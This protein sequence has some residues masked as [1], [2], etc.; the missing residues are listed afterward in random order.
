MRLPLISTCSGL[1]TK[2][3]SIKLAEFLWTS[4]GLSV[5]GRRLQ[6]W[7]ASKKS[8]LLLQVSIFCR[9]R[10]KSPKRHTFFPVEVNL[11]I[12]SS[13]Y[14]RKLSGELCWRYKTP[15]ITFF[16]L[17]KEI[18]IHNAW[19]DSVEVFSKTEQLSVSSTKRPTPPHARGVGTCSNR[20]V[21]YTHLTLPTSD[22]V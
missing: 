10:L 15:Q 20:A 11:S 9:H 19:K 16:F 12:V 21:S 13:K 2:M 3:L 18:S 1:F 6:L 22:L 4:V 17:T 7:R 8:R 5:V 14:L